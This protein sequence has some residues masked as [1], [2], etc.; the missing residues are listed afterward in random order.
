MSQE[1]WNGLERREMDRRQLSMIEKKLDEH[2][3]ILESI[4]ST[5]SAVAVQN[6]Q[7]QNI[8]SMQNE[9][10]GD[11]NEVYQKIEKI[12]GHQASCPRKNI[13]AIWCVMI[14]ISLSLVGAFI[15]HVLAGK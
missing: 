2:S 14:S 1:N 10:R 11:I 13:S 3:E 9:M 15:A 12:N 4:R 7:I 8:Q 6:V 5:L